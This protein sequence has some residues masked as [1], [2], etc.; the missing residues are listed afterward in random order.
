MYPCSAK[1]DSQCSSTISGKVYT[2]ARRLAFVSLK[3]VT[4]ILEQQGDYTAL[5]TLTG[6]TH[7][8]LN[9]LREECVVLCVSLCHLSFEITLRSFT[10]HLKYTFNQR[11]KKETIM[12]PCLDV[13][14]ASKMGNT[15]S[16]TTLPLC[17]KG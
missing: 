8:T 9:C 12:R 13:M 4:Q 2:S 10:A 15:N 3:S 16:V 14:I 7:S 11:L 1:N 5:I 6:N 17:T